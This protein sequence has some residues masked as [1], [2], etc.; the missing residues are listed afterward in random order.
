M[1]PFALLLL[2]LQDPVAARADTLLSHQQLAPARALAERVV[3]DHPDDP[4]AHL[5]LG[6]IWL[7]WPTIGG[8][9]ALE[10]FRRAARLAPADPVPLYYETRVG[11]RL[12]DDEGEALVREAALR[13]LAIDPNY[14]D[15]WDLFAA[16]YHDDGIWRRAERALA[17]HPEDLL[18]VERRAGIALALGAPV[19]AD[20]LAAVLLERHAAYIPAALIRAQANFDAGSDALGYA[21]YDSALAHADLDSTGAIW[22]QVWM[23]ASP[24]EVARHDSTAPP[25]QPEFYRWFWLRR[26]PNLVTPQNERV[27]EHFRRLAFV[28]RAFH[29]L[30]PYSRYHHSPTWRAIMESYDRDAGTGRVWGVGDTVGTETVY[31]KAGF[32]ARGI[33]WIRHG[34]PDVWEGGILD[35]RRPIKISSALDAAAWEYDTPDGIL[36]VGLQNVRGGGMI[37]NPVTPRQFESARVLLATDRTSMPAPLEAR[38]WTAFFKGTDPGTTDIYYRAAPDT[39]AVALWHPDG[40]LVVRAAGAGVLELT[41]PPGKYWEGF[42]VDSA[43]VLGRA[44]REVQAPAFSRVALGLSSLVLAPGDAR[45]G[46]EATLDAMPADLVYPAGQ[47]LSTYAEIYGV[48]PDREGIARYAVRYTFAPERGLAARLLGKDQPVVFEFTRDAPA[49][50]A[51][52]EALT[53]EPGRLPPGRYRVTLAVTDLRRN[54]KSETVALVITVR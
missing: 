16:V 2:A 14:A 19:R 48:A 38:V 45:R 41:V 52:P 10:E 36:T 21:W 35:P 46:R 8:Y 39:A 4:D 51:I 7:S 43:G 31:A 27:A 12:G 22:D 47:P 50:V 13:I 26:D 28:R 1:M 23:I 6:R 53:I 9:Q 32:D 49:A 11:I 18:A 15:A 3:T 29:L 34:P 44:R 40:D 37:L 5:L 30:H 42:D 33:L 54:V 25:D 24:T 20:S 17:L